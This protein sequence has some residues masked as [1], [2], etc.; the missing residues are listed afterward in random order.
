MH[1]RTLALVLVALLGSSGTRADDGPKHVNPSPAYKAVGPDEEARLAPTVR[2][3]VPALDDRRLGRLRAGAIETKELPASREGALHFQALGSVDAPASEVMAV[4]RD[5]PARAGLFPHVERCAAAWDRNVALVDMQLGVAFKTVR[6]RL[7]MQHYGDQAVVWEYVHGD[8]K[9]SR[10][11]Y[12]LFPYDDGARTLVQYETE[13]EPDSALPNFILS[14]LT[15]K[16]LP[17]VIEALRKGVADRR[18]R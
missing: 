5:Y 13:S 6:Y 7:A 15:E 16:G 10:G 12:K 1:L 18:S 14:A 4:L 9:D 2:G 3:P 11:S 8:L 17:G